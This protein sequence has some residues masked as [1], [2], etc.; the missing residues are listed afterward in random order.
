VRRTTIDLVRLAELLVDRLGS[1]LPAGVVAG[2]ATEQDLDA[3]RA[4]YARTSAH[5]PPGF[6]QPP[7]YGH[8]DG[9]LCVSLPP[10]RRD[11][12]SR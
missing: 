4:M 5:R 2:T 11:A 1:G 9:V 12:S 10:R 7:E 8:A 6:P 3:V